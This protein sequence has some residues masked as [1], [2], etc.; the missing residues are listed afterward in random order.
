MKHGWDSFKKGNENI[1]ISKTAFTRQFDNNLS[2]E[3]SYYPSYHKALQTGEYLIITIPFKNEQWCTCLFSSARL[4]FLKFCSVHQLLQ[5]RILNDQ[6]KYV[7]INADSRIILDLI[8]LLW[9]VLKNNFI[10]TKFITSDRC[11]PF[12][13]TC[14]LMGTLWTIMNFFVLYVQ[15]DRLNNMRFFDDIILHL[16]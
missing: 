3:L 12:I 13:R 9:S 6:K 7:S 4:D 2:F 14:K 11:S 10:Y 15:L 16:F 8:Y 5:S 1:Q